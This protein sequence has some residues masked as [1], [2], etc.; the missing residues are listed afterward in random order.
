MIPEVVIP[1]AEL[2][3]GKLGICRLLV[4]LG[5]AKSNNEGRRAVEGGGVTLGP[6]REKVADPKANVAVTDGLIVC[7]GKRQVARVRLS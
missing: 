6:D 2:N 7:V 3:D 5:L 4:L 1:A